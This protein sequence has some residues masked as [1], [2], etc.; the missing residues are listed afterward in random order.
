SFITVSIMDKEKII[1][2]LPP[3]VRSFIKIISRFKPPDRVLK[4]KTI[5]NILIAY[6]I[7]L[8]PLVAYSIYMVKMHPKEEASEVQPDEPAFIPMVKVFKVSQDDFSDTLSV[9]G[10]VKGT[11]EV[12]LKFEIQG[13]IATFNFREGDSVSENEV[14]S[15]LDPMDVITKLKH[16]KSKYDTA[17]S[18]F[19]AAREK[20]KVYRE[21]YDMGAIIRA[22]LNEM[23][24]S[25]DSLKAEVDAAKSEVDLSQSQ[26]EKTVI[27]APA[28]GIMGT[29]KQ[30]EG[31]FVAPTDIIGTFLEVT[32]VFVEVGVIEKDIN[33]VEIDQKVTVRV[34]AYPDE[35][36]L[37]KVD[38]I[39]KEI[40]GETRTLPVKVILVNPEQKLFSGMYADCDIF[41]A[42]FLEKMIVPNSSIIDI[43]QM[44]VVPIVKTE[45]EKIGTIELR[46]I[47]TG[48]SSSKYTVVN[49]GLSAGEFV[50]METQ[51]PLKDGMQV[52]II[53]TIEA[54]V[55]D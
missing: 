4:P 31:N 39:S 1:E 38:N 46:K 27:K 40:L 18:R 12:E 19:E 32:N 2:R 15:S 16:S 20:L 23:E 48:Y 33:K 34:D 25:V 13:K 24:L 9:N 3:S 53:E 49:E 21:L 55:N 52:K 14:I 54:E 41:L 35:I 30:E 17:E 51:Q 43:G 10:T 22:K 6:I 45:D 5:R 29:K 11:K 42:E 44:V 50:V 7:L 36:F 37:G 8:A 47:D 26:L 28:D